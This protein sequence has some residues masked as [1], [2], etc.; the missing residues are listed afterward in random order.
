MSIVGIAASFRTGSYVHRLAQAA[1]F[2]AAGEEYTT[3][4]G[5]A[6]VPPYAAGPLPRPA[7]ELLG[8][9]AGAD[10]LLLVTPGHS[11]LP[12]ELRNALSW[13]AREPFAEVL[14]GRPVAVVSAAPEPWNAMWA[15]AELRTLLAGYGGQMCGAELVV[16]ADPPLFDA[17][18]RLAPG[19]TRDRFVEVF[20]EL[21][22]AAHARVTATLPG[23]AVT[24]YPATGE[25]LGLKTLASPFAAEP[26]PAERGAAPAAGLFSGDDGM[27]A[28]AK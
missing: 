21:R 19:E 1:R 24:G 17:T 8:A 4:D 10:G 27:L 26:A 5:L 23:I 18:G 2:E 12:A 7:R 9:L 14:E 13:L 6:E 15:H 22:A 11:L 3:W 28:A 16:T 25:R 20:K